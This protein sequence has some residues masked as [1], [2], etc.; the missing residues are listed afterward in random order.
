MPIGRATAALTSKE[1]E[2][3][4]VVGTYD[5]GTASSGVK[6]YVNGVQSDEANAEVNPGSFV[7]ME[8]LGGAVKVGMYS[9]HYANGSITETSLWDKELS[10]T[11]VLE[12]FNDGKAL[13]ALTH[14]ATANIKG[15]WRNNGLSTWTDLKGSNNGTPTNITETILI[16]QGVDSTRDAQGFIMNKQKDTSCLNLTS[17]SGGYVR[18]Q[19]NS[20]VQLAGTAASWVFWVKLDSLSDGDQKLISKAAST[21]NPSSAYQI[22]TNSQQLLLQ[23]YSGGWRSDAR[24]SFFTSTDWVHV[25]VTIDGSNNVNFYKNGDVFGSEAD[26]GYA[27]PANTG[28]LHIGIRAGAQGSTEFLKGQIDGVLLYNKELD[29]TE[30]LKNYNATKGNHRN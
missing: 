29:S 27:V 4:H 11:E 18:V 15:Y 22:R 7:A 1:G 6:V 24:S 2:W 13:D 5:G 10:S 14:S 17:K 30:V 20:N 9:N 23:I 25:V 19:D 12:L 28:G 26:I 16:P 8:N 3:L 21:G